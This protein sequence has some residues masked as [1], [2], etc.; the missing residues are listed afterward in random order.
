MSEDLGIAGA[1]FT[2]GLGH[3][4]SYQVAGRP[5]V[6]G[7]ILH[8]GSSVYEDG[9]HIQFPRVTKA[10][11]VYNRSDT[12]DIIVHFASKADPTVVEGHRYVTVPADPGA[13]DMFYCPSVACRDLYISVSP[14]EGA[15][16]GAV[17]FVEVYAELTRIP[18]VD[19]LIT[20]SGVSGVN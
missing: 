3:V 10:I 7:G 8:S 5:W 11:C 4:G 6:S 20:G 15:G 12:V 13:E 16:A 9:W 18:S 2:P 1:Y 14:K 19:L 17:D